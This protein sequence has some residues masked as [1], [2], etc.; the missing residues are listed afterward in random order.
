MRSHSW[1]NVRAVT[2][3]GIVDDA[4]VAVEHGLIT[5]VRVGGSAPADAVDG[6]GL[7]LVPGLVDCHSDGLEKEVSP[8]SSVR[9]P[10]DFAMTSFEGRVRAAGITTVFH[11]VGFQDKAAIGRS[12]EQAIAMC[13]VI[14]DHQRD[15][16]R[17]IDH[18]ILFR[19]EALDPAAF[20][21]LQAQVDAAAPHLPASPPIVSFEDHTPGQGQYRDIAAYASM[22]EREQRGV[23][24]VEHVRRVMAEAAEARPVRDRNLAAVG[25]L[26]DAGRI[27]LLAHDP[28]TTEAIEIA[29]KAGAGIAEF[30]V[31]LDAARHARSL[32]MC[33]VMGA[34]NA[35]RGVSHSGN[36][37]ARELVHHGLCDALASDYLPSTMLA[38]AFT[39]ASEDVCTLS[40]AIA[41]VTSGPAAMTGC[42]DRGRLEPGARADLVLVDD[43]HRWPVVVDVG[44]SRH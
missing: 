6:G 27:S 30:P 39:L 25:E 9:F 31:A 12:V 14:V 40:E 36:V 3:T 41:L 8:R 18:S 1:R 13:N 37:S 34:P 44:T 7:L 16:A 26:A 10:V 24:A 5:E 23:D 21:A 17:L 15:D 2:P 35:L 32:G 42:D 43:R 33:I 11:G 20:D 28:D 29:A 19:F 4:T 22:I 38:A